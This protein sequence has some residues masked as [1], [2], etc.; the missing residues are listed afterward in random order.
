MFKRGVDWKLLFCLAVL[1]ILGSVTTYRIVDLHLG[2]KS[3][4]ALYRFKKDI[5][6]LRGGIY[7][8]GD[9]P[10]PMAVSTVAWVYHVDP[11]SIN[12]DKHH[13]PESVARIVSE[14]L[15]IPYDET[16]KAFSETDGRRY[17]PL[18]PPLET[19]ASDEI[20]KFLVTNSAVSGLVIEESQVR[21]YPGGQRMGS[22]IGYLN[23]A[24]DP[25][26]GIEQTFDEYLRGTPGRVE[27]RRDARR[28]EIP[29]R[30]V[31][32]IDPVRGANVYLTLDRDIQQTAEEALA[33]AVST[34]NAAGGFAIVEEVS[35]GRILA[36]ASC[37]D[38]DPADVRNS[39]KR[40]NKNLA[41]ACNYEPGSMMKVITCAAA[42]SEGVLR[43]DTKLPIGQGSWF[44]A[45]FTLRDHPTGIIDCADAIAKSSNIYFAKTVVGDPECGFKGLGARALYA[46]L[47]A[48]GFGEQYHIGLPGGQSGIL[49]N[50]KKWSNIQSS[51]VPIGQG[52][53]VTGLQMANAY[54]AVANDGTRMK[55]YL[56][57]RVVAENGDVL[58]ENKPREICRAIQPRAARALREMMKGTATREG[59][60]R[61]AAVRGYSVAG[62]TGTAQRTVN[63]RYSQSEYWASFCG[64]LPADDPKVVILV[65]V[66]RPHPIHTGGYV[67]A[68]AFRKIAEAAIRCLEIPP[69][70]PEELLEDEERKWREN[71]RNA[72]RGG[73]AR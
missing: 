41:I 46:Y 27:G 38:F 8:G 42:L 57:E 13:T 5:P 39:R 50:W 18:K 44:Y 21:N 59:T 2:G 64:M 23:Y 10:Y 19:A 69:D 40:D 26:Y 60:A 6:G 66:D 65:S 16:L 56:V 20:H 1:A 48:F 49:R 32:K 68:P 22:I 70:K 58:V 14:A 45:G 11:G 28:R 63:G 31:V 30:R 25:Y 51:R 3:S 36:L 37:P 54:A 24:G 55:P 7:F 67:A 34:N 4:D 62:K 61:R 17:I 12:R 47:K 29:E 72:R 9:N 35:T 33:E 52:I 15:R 73:A 43:P 53:S 71:L